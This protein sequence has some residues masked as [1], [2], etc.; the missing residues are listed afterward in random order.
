MRQKI[1]RRDSLKFG[2][3]LGVAAY[4]GSVEP[5]GAT[6]AD[7]TFSKDSESEGGQFWD[8]V[9][10]GNGTITAKRFPF[11]KAAHP[12]NFLTYDIPPSA[13]E[14]VHT[15]I[16]DD[17]E[18]GSFDEFY[19]IV[20]GEGQMKIDGENITVGKG[21]HVFTPIG[22]SHGIENT[23]ATT[24]LKVFLTFVLR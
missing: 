6:A 22:I 1:S 18:A 2:I 3:T 12:A 21:D 20:S 5:D 15:H 4:A 9:H 17:E 24:N 11:S 19:Y 13:S 10:G 23:S 8:R 14:G 16:L 7:R